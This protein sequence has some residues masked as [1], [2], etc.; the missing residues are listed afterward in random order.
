MTS[1][2]TLSGSFISRI[3]SVPTLA[4]SVFF[5]MV[6]PSVFAEPPAA[7]R[8]NH[9]GIGGTLILAGG[10]E[11]PEAAEKAYVDAIRAASASAEPRVVILPQ[12]SEAP[13]ES[14]TKTAE[15][16]TNLGIANSQISAATE[17]QP[18]NLQQTV[19]QIREA[20]AVWIGGGQ[21]SRLS[22][23]FANTQ[24][25][26][27]LKEL[28]K[29]GGVIGGTSAGA[30][31]MSKTMIA[32][33]TSEPELGVGFDLI[34]GAI[35]D[36]HFTERDRIH[37]SRLAVTAN[38]GH[39]GLGIDES[40][41]V[42]LEKR[43]LRV[44]GKGSVTVL[45]GP[46]QHRLADEF[47]LK[48]GGVADLT[49]LRR[50]ALSRASGQNPGETKFGKTEVPS[51]ALVI[52]GGGGMPKPI[53]DRFLELAGGPN[54]RIVVLPTAVPREEAFRQRVPGFLREASTASI[55]ILPQSR[56]EEVESVEFQDALKDA[57]GV[58][59]GGGRQWNFVDAYENTSAV[60]LFRDVLRRG[61]VIGGSSA[62]AT[63]QG[64]FL[65][66]GHPLGNTVMM[67][68]GYERGFAFL[69]GS[70]I[71]QH[72]SQRG[73]KP[74]LI[75]VIRRHPDM[76]GIGID[77]STAIVVQGTNVSVIGDHSAHFL[78]SK[79]LPAESNDEK[80]ST[81][82]EINALYISIPSGQHL[83]LS[84]L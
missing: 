72:F 39:F 74:D 79:R 57:T 7:V 46:S 61:G 32:S 12:A 38:P 23:L 8:I 53:V 77:E 18:D 54:A 52:V 11:I 36:Q 15:W 25:E 80:D 19:E 59:F 3:F 31:I 66:R 9:E 81:P 29:R 20:H 26:A 43:T 50:A 35:V 22:T 47:Q 21:Q 4:L 27:E 37:R 75:P 5:G 2:G 56:T 42:I 33:G 49:Q 62:G 67:A 78:S 14:G 60:E 76:L 1:S 69:P 17:Q 40:T 45:L 28:L 48:D 6:S 71:D 82:E 64:E 83:D 55:R 51:G 65:V 58:W 16:L 13:L 10:G 73:R 41:A 84:T 63:I 68:E 30:A 34:P 70:A 44:T 24:V